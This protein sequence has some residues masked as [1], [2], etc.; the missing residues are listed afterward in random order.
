MQTILTD[1]IL[2]AI[3]ERNFELQVLDLS[4]SEKI[5]DEGFIQSCQKIEDSCRKL[6]VLKIA[7]LKVSLEKLTQGLSILDST[8]NN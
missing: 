5:S 7:K 2:A 1:D 3:L 8:L 4:H 6:Q